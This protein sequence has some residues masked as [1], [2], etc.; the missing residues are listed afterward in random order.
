[1]WVR[2]E[3]FELMISFAATLAEDF[4]RADK[5]TSVAIDGHAPLQIRRLRDLETF[6]DHLA[7]L[8]PV[9]ASSKM[10]ESAMAHRSNVIGFAPDGPRGVAAWVQGQRIAAT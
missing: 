8:E 1:V 7:I 3:Q 6:L 5:L 4:F 10:G 9:N 2:K